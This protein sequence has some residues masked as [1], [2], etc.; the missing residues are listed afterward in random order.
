MLRQAQHDKSFKVRLPCTPV[1]SL[2]YLGQMS[3][4]TCLTPLRRWNIGTHAMEARYE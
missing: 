3:Y 2:S 1:E 4:Y